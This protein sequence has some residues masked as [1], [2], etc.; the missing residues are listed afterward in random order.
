MGE[1][2]GN[3]QWAIGN[4]QLAIGKVSQEMK[5]ELFEKK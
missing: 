4:G 3:R 1:S 5:I 2:L